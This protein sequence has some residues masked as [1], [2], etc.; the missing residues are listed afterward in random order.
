ML[1]EGSFL[2]EKQ[3][4]SYQKLATLIKGEEKIISRMRLYTTHFY[5]LK[6]VYIFLSSN[7]TFGNSCYLA[8]IYD[9]PDLTQQTD[10][11]HETSKEITIACDPFRN[12]SETIIPSYPNSYAKNYTGMCDMYDDYDSHSQNSFLP[13]PALIFKEEKTAISKEPFE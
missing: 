12:I 1:F 9:D 3:L 5:F 8:Y 2:S 6:Y 4:H 10:S 7:I 13:S 11:L